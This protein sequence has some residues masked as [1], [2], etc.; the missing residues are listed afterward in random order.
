MFTLKFYY[1]KLQKSD[2]LSCLILKALTRFLRNHVHTFDALNIDCRTE[3]N[4]TNLPKK[5]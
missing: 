5:Y 4:V 1:P 2:K 3:K